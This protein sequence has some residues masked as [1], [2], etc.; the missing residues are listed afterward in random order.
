MQGPRGARGAGVLAAAVIASALVCA[1]ADE[2]RAEEPFEISGEVD[3]LYPGTDV[4]LTA[5]IAN[6][7]PFAIQVVSTRATVLDA[8]DGCPASLLEIDDARSSV[9]IPARGIGSVSL[10]VRLDRAAPDA[11]QGATWP[12]LFSGTA[13]NEAAAE[14]P[15]TS[16]LG[17]VRNLG[18]VAFVVALAAFATLLAARARRRHHGRAP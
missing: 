10:R 9:E 14:L 12:L 18:L 16:A 5:E 1:S 11:C 2:V 6:P 7:Y 8:R 4:T 17:G 13:V 3:G 15:E